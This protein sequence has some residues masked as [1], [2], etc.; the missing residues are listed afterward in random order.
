MASYVVYPS[1]ESTTRLLVHGR[2]ATFL[3]S[4][5]EDLTS[6]PGVV[7]ASLSQALLATY[8]GIAT[9]RSRRPKAW[10]TS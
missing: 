2:D 8:A 4:T 3:T 10:S 9:S 5:G 1:Y 6:Q 7:D